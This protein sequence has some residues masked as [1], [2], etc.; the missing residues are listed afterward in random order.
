LVFQRQ[1]RIIEERLFG[2]WHPKP[3][4]TQ[5]SVAMCS[6]HFIDVTGNSAYQVYAGFSQKIVER[7]AHRTTDDNPDAK[8]FYFTGALEN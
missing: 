7:F 1:E 6:E 2:A 5:R 3:I 4:L 8:L